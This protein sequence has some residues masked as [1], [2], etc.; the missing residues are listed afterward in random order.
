M[1]N[2]A[3]NNVQSIGGNELYNI[4]Y[5]FMEM[6]KRDSIKTYN[7]YLKHYN[8]FF[9][10][11]VGKDLWSIIWDDILK[12]TYTDVENFQVFM[13]NE[14]K[15]EPSTC[16]AKL[17]A[18]KSL[19]KKLHKH[20][21]NINFGIL[22]FEEIDKDK[23]EDTSY[24]SLTTEEVMNLIEF[25]KS[26]NKGD[27]QAMIFEFLF[28]V[29]CRKNVPFVLAEDMITR[30]YDYRAQKEA[31]V[32]TFKDKGKFIDKSISDEFYEK[33]MGF[34]QEGK[35]KI[36]DISH[37]PVETTFEEFRKTYKLEYKNGK[38]V[39]IHS[40]KK[41]SGWAGYKATNDLNKV[42]EHMQHDHVNTTAKIYL[43]S[44]D[45][46]CSQISYMMSESIGMEIF[47]GMSREDL[48]GLIEKCGKDTLYRM[49]YVMEN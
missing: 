12:I 7:N 14:K 30:K 26:R 11:I 44:K 19:W 45:D 29:G 21:R 39:V 48:I 18:V 31:W 5:N 27:I 28:V 33:I 8:D 3:L 4:I 23:N 9:G 24:A 41:A 25:A 47:D 15:W 17:F 35:K 40:I 13:L 2:L 38:K 32:I 46:Y 37:V 1:S 36:F 43:D 34:K 16:N 10:F 42:K 20:N 6:K 22:N 49:K